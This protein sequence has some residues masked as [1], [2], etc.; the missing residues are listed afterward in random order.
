MWTRLLVALALGA[1]LIA[2]TPAGGS[3]P[4]ATVEPSVAAPSDAG[5]HA[6]RLGG[7]VGVLTQADRARSNAGSRSRG[8]ASSCRCYVRAVRRSPRGAR[9]AREWRPAPTLGANEPQQA[10]ERPAWGWRYRMSII[11]WIVVGAIAGYLAGFLV[12]GDEGL[13]VIGHLVLGI[14]GALVGGFLAEP[15]AQSRSDERHQYRDDRR[16]DDRRRDHGP[17]GRRGDGSQPRG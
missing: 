1:A 7:P 10:G 12:K 17:R 4:A 15:A 5:S 3:S 11:A 13:G 14:V 16:R 2:C 9:R 8:P 6:E